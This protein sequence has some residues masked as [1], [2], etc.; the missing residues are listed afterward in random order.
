MSS[1]VQPRWKVPEYTK[2]QIN[3][4]GQI[5]RNPNA[6]NKDV[7]YALKII[8][9]WRAAHAYPMHIF[10]MNLRRNVKSHPDIIVVERLKRL[11]SI[12]DKLRR[13]TGMELY[14]MQDL[15]GCRM[16]LP[17]LDEVYEYSK[18]FKDS[19]IRHEPK[20][21]KDYIQDPKKSGYRSLHLI[22][23]FKT[24][25]PDKQIF[26]QYPMLI[27]LQF[28]THLQHIWATAIETIGLF[29]HQDLKSGQG[30]EEFKRFFVLVSSLFAIREN[31][32]I[33]PGTIRDEKELVSEIQRI[34]TQCHILDLL[35]AINAVVESEQENL[36]GKKG[37]FI[38]LLNYKERILRKKYFKPIEFELANKTYSE[39]ESN[40]N[41]IYDDIVLVGA[42]SFSAVKDAYPNY[43]MDISEF[44]RLVKGYLQ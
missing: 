35:S 42:S 26:N 7:L 36:A 30:S 3:E 16:V 9:N 1:I 2:S 14:R 18:K 17:S 43:F 24:N 41:N 31:C 27:E 44:V 8:D 11:N 29:T 21:P 12:V 15:G 34:D 10:Y 20:S 33:V 32:P 23:K 19:K 39:L 5:M 25:T 38:L 13:E 37:Y 40:P 28:R 4:A 6:T 22:Y